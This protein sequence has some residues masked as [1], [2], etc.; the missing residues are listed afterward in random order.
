MLR[1]SSRTYD[2]WSGDARCRVYFNY[3]VV[4]E[5]LGNR[6]KA[7]TQYVN[8]VEQQPEHVGAIIN[9]GRQLEELGREEEALNWY[10]EHIRKNKTFADVRY[11]RGTLLLRQNRPVEALDDLKREALNPDELRIVAPGSA[12]NNRAEALIRLGRFTDAMEPV[13]DGLRR[14]PDDPDLKAKLERLSASGF[15]A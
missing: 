6:E 15:G 8:A 1:Q 4:L 11:N 12:L 2:H 10:T 9:A 5:Q 3:G 13:L 14:M 7:L